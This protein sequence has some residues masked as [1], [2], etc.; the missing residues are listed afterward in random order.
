LH[1]QYKGSSNVQFSDFQRSLAQGY[2]A[3]VLDGFD[4]IEPSSRSNIEKQIL[5]I[6]RQYEK[7][8]IIVSGRPDERFNAWDEF[9]IYNV[10]P[11]SYDS[12][13]QLIINSDYDSDVKKQF[14]KKLTPDFFSKHESFLSIP[15]LAIMLGIVDKG[16]PQFD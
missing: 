13:K 3:L 11:M 5:D 12:T 1:S 6:S 7:V 9:Y 4:E 10:C 8:P 14:L 16:Y 2:F 15:L